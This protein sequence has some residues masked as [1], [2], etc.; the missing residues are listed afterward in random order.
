M[1]N[2][3]KSSHFV[4]RWYPRN[5]ARIPFA[6]MRTPGQEDQQPAPAATTKQLWNLMTLEWA[7]RFQMGGQSNSI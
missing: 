1:M 2:D 3:N 7:R 4:S 6:F 5:E